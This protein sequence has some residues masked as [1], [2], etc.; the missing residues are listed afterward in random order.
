MKMKKK[1]KRCTHCGKKKKDVE[2]RVDP[3]QEEIY[4]IKEYSNFCDDCYDES[5]QEI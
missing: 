1:Y 2:R 5:A 3:Y 4:D